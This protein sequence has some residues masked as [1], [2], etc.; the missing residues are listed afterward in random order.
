M[1]IRVDCHSC[2]AA[3]QAADKHAGK[4]VRCPKC[5]TVLEIPERP[6]KKEANL[7]FD[8]LPDLPPVAPPA[9]KTTFVPTAGKSK[10]PSKPKP[11]PEPEDEFG[12]ELYGSS[13]KSKADDEDD[14]TST[15]DSDD[16]GGEVIREPK[17]KPKKKKKS[18]AERLEA[19][20]GPKWRQNLY[21]AL[22]LALIPLC[23]HG[24]L[25]GRPVHERYNETIV[26][27]KLDSDPVDDENSLGLAEAHELAMLTPDHKLEG[28]LLA[29]DTWLHWLF[30][31]LSAATFLGLFVMMWPQAEAGTVKLITIGLI[32]GTVGIFLLLTFQFLAIWTMGFNI[33]GRSVIVLLFYIVKFI[34]FSYRCALDPDNG[35]LLSFMGFTC[36]VGL[37]EELCKA[38]PVAIYL[39]STEKPSWRGA[40]LVGLASGV[41]FGVSEGITY[42]SDY[43]NGLFEG[44]IYVVRFVSCV[45]LHA[46]WAGA[47]AVLMYHNQ[48]YISELSWENIL[49]FI[50]FY[51][52]IP[53]VLHGLY[54]TLL[55]KE[56][57]VGAMLIAGVSFGWFA[58]MV[59]RSRHDE[60][61]LA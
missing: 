5:E 35:F 53:M 7:D 45:A 10:S 1:S 14:W 6:A 40:C 56:M 27:H 39:N 57:D 12:D 18:P 38:I 33:R 3:I 42:S 54:D 48:D 31:A 11:K 58:F 34:G 20:Q 8:V 2:G 49:G 19:I 30:A 24:A 61:A 43:Y 44:W 47:A 51:L 17:S 15:L 55:K 28:A 9:P 22:L 32:T 46:L 37:C 36:G 13:S 23:L 59:T 50:A 60:A 25:Q 41:G 52:L 21:W 26:V 4:K 29:V 16:L